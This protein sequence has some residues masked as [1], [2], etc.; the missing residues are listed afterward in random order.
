MLET[1]QISYNPESQTYTHT[2]SANQDKD[3]NSGVITV[4][5]IG[6]WVLQPIPE[7]IFGQTR[8]YSGDIPDRSTQLPLSEPLYECRLGWYYSPSRTTSKRTGQPLKKKPSYRYERTFKG[9]LFLGREQDDTTAFLD[10]VLKMFPEEN[11]VVFIPQELWSQYPNAQS[12]TSPNTT[13]IGTGQFITNE[14]EINE[15]GTVTVDLNSPVYSP[16]NV[17]PCTPGVTKPTL[18]KRFLNWL[19]LEY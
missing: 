16:I 9:D 13:I 18:W 2:Y 1:E 19:S 4:G 8:L 5:D 12:L 7:D 15:L 17:S 6:P 14:P 3:G 11:Y 10:D